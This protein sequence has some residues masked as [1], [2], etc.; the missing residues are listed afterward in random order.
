[1]ILDDGLKDREIFIYRLHDINK[2]GS[3]DIDAIYTKKT[4]KKIVFEN[5]LFSEFVI[6]LEKEEKNKDSNTIGKPDLDTGTSD[7]SNMDE[8]VNSSI[9]GSKVS[10]YDNTRP[11]GILM[12]SMGV[13]V[14]I[15]LIV[16]KNK[17][18]R[19]G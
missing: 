15:Y 18:R 9:S 3:K 14:I 5:H 2:D 16:N 8:N 7:V 11:I 17:K 10:T 1:M 6:V 12:S 19:T 4:D 13:T